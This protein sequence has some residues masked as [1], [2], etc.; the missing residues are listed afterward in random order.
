MKEASIYLNHLLK[1][2]DV[3][4]LAL[5]GG[6]DSMCLLHLLLEIRALKNIK[7]VCVHI[8]H[9]TRDACN[10]EADFVEKYVKNQSVSFEYFKIDKY[11]K[12]KFSENEAREKR[13]RILKDVVKNNQATYLFT[14]HH[15]DDLVET[16]L[17]RLLRGSTLLGYAGFKQESIWDDVKIIRPLIYHT[18]KEIL[19]YLQVNHI[20]YVVDE[21]NFSTQYLRNK[22]R[23]EIL[24]VFESI[25]P[26]YHK[27]V[28]KYSET[29]QKINQIVECDLSILRKDI[30]H[31]HKILIEKFLLLDNNLQEEFLRD[32]L[33]SFY[34]ENI[35]K[36]SEKHIVLI[37]NFIMN[38]KNV[39][40]ID[41]P[42][43]IIM[44]KD[45]KYV[46]L[47][48]KQKSENFCIK[49]EEKVI[50][51]NEDI[52]QKINEYRNKSNYEIHLN[53]SS[54]T[55]PLYLTTRKDGMRMEVK[56]LGGSKK[57]NDILIDSKV[58]NEE[59]DNIPILI[60]SSGTVLWILGIKKSKY[61]LDKNENYDIIYQYIK[62]EGLD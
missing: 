36:I 4:V 51:S 48:K 59:K 49:L 29:I 21:S 37:L 32:Y 16:V 45:G 44:K 41:L 40:A 2:E 56:N 24:P 33:K 20:P 39:L 15:G 23:H 43:Q 22:I 31:N 34:H 61:D 11:E 26:G 47:M 46:W 12:G 10:E 18:K 17:M 8:N 35:N 57:V 19:E 58:L 38:K 7:I 13:Y 27:K 55:L 62:K 1:E 52:V 14:A 28:L 60:D 3:C 50:L 25:E 54:I 42:N 53:S 30:I 6:P 5:S 9:N